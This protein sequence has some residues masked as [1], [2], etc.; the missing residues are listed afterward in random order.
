MHRGIV[1]RGLSVLALTAILAFAGVRP[2]AAAQEDGIFAR[3][4]HWLAM[5]WDAPAAERSLS[6]TWS[7]AEQVDKGLGVDPNGGS[8]IIGNPD[9]PPV[10]EGF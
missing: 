7:A 8:K 4:L 10:S 2:A 3:T 9:P 1:H 6:A 5:M